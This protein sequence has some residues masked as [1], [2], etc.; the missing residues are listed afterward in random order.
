MKYEA[1]KKRLK[2]NGGRIAAVV[3]VIVLV[4]LI[5]LPSEEKKT[6]TVRLDYDPETT[7]T[8]VTDDVR[9]LISDSG[10]VRYQINSPLWLMFNEASRP[11]WKFPDGLFLE[12]FDDTMAVNA[13]FRCDSATYFSDERLWRFDGNVRMLNDLGDRFL[14]QQLYW[15]Q[16][17]HKIRSDSFIHIERSDRVIEGYGFESN[18]NITIYRVHRPSMI[19]P[20]SDFRRAQN[21][22]LRSVA[23]SAD[24]TDPARETAPESDTKKVITDPVRLDRSQIKLKE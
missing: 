18:E 6:E 19:L 4:I 9:T 14:T 17:D 7:P 22:S 16:L 23:A 3:A 24:E 5:A 10:Y 12:K 8:M 11:A 15:D 20:M 2:R 1:L 21:D 13:T